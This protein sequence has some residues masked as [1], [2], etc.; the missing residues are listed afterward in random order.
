MNAAFMRVSVYPNGQN[1]YKEKRGFGGT[2]G[3]GGTAASAY[4]AAHMGCQEGTPSNAI[5]V[6]YCGGDPHVVSVR[7][8]VA[9]GKR[10]DSNSMK[11]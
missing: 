3:V 9:P 5:S 8:G 1:P 2:G 4:V 7:S 10:A 6:A 11:A